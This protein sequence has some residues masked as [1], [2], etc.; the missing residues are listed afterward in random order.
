MRQI[1]NHLQ[2]LLKALY[3]DLVHH[4]SKDNGKGESGDQAVKAQGNGVGKQGFYLEGIEKG[5][6]MFKS[7]PF[8]TLN[9]HLYH[10]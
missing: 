8:A 3:P 9:P 2:R 1:G 6:E 4:Q 7:H 10:L 5:L